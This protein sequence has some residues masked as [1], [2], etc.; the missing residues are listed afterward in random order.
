MKRVHRLYGH[1]S[2]LEA[3][4]EDFLLHIQKASSVVKNK[5][6]SFWRG[7]HCTLNLLLLPTYDDNFRVPQIMNEETTSDAD[8][9]LFS[10]KVPS[11]TWASADWLW[12]QEY[13]LQWNGDRHV[14]F[15]FSIKLLATVRTSWTLCLISCSRISICG[16]YAYTW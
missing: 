3:K 9:Y 14:A 4:Q 10:V 1:R 15:D 6:F 7:W 8:D 5:C 13:V 12:W 16:F 2:V 11:G